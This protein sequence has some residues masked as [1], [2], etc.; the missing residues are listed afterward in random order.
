[1]FS[2]PKFSIKR[3]VCIFI[4]I[5]SLIIFGTSS[6]FQMPMESTPEMEFPILMVMTSYYG[7]SPE[8]IDESVTDKIESALS[9]VS[10][11][12]TTM[13]V[14]MENVGMTMLEFSYDADMD[15]KYQDVTSALAM[16]SLP[17]G[18]SDPTV[19][20]MNIS[21]MAN[22]SIM[23]LSIEASSGE[24]LKAYVE[25][26]IVP[27]LERIEGVS[28]VSIFGGSRQY[29]QILLDENKM[30]QYHLT[31]SSVAN[32]IASSE[33]EITM[34]SLD[35]GNVTVELT[36][37]QE[38]DNYRTLE[39]V[40]ITLVSGDV[41]HLSDVAQVNMADEE[42]TSYSRRDGK[43]TMSLSIM[44]DQ[45]ANTVSIC[46]QVAQVVDQLNHSNLGLTMEIT[47][48][49]GQDI[50]DNLSQVALA[51]VEGLAIAV[52]VLWL[53]LGEWRASLIIG[54]SMPFSVLATLILMSAFGMTINLISLGGLVIGIGM[55]VD[56][57]IVVIDSCFKSGTM[58]RSFEENIIKGAELVMGSITASTLTTVV[59]FLPI[60][61][62]DGLAGQLFHDICYTIVFSLTA[63]LISAITLVPL[64]FVKLKPKEKTDFLGNRLVHRLEA[65]YGRIMAKLFDKRALVVITAV[66]LMI[67]AVG[68]FAMVPKELIPDMTS[69]QIRL[70]VETKNGLNLESTNE[71][72][73]QLEELVSQQPDVESY[74]MQVG[75]S[76]GLATLMG[77]GAGTITVT[78]REDASMTESEFVQTIRD[79]SKSVPNCNVDVSSVSMMSML[80][81]G[82]VELNLRGR[83][84]NDLNEQAGIIRDRM[85]QMPEFD[86]VTTSLTDGAPR[87]KIQVDPILAASVNMTP[88]SVLASVRS[89]LSG[90]EAITI[91]DGG[92]EY[93]VVVELPTDRFQDVSDLYGMMVDTP[94][95]GKAALTD[96][97]EI[98]YAEAPTS[99][100]REGGDYLVT[101]TG[102]PKVGLNIAQLSTEVMNDIA[103]NVELPD[104]VEIDQ[105]SMMEQMYEEFAAIGKALL[106][107]VYLVFAVMAIQFESIR[108][109]GVVMIS[110]PFALVGSFLGLAITGS[111]VNMASLLG[112]VMLVGIVV[113]NAIVLID[114]TNILRREYGFEIRQAL[115]QA[116]ISRLRPIL[117]STLTTIVGLLPMA[118]GSG[119]EMMESMAVVVIG[120]LLMSTLLTLVL[121]PTFYLIFDPEDRR[122][123]R[124][125]RKAAKEKAQAAQ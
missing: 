44:K 105:G 3:P 119:V 33:F 6:V 92:T 16:V 37:S 98:V 118:L 72:M 5:A 91:Q 13:S 88:A 14:S 108:F 57:S 42:V 47:S 69:G 24:N 53:F 10:E 8:E 29:I 26:T 109:S 113:N 68:L 61:L 75:D 89:Q 1:M 90:V 110:V 117:M 27:E 11:V 62:M 43:D 97:A 58:E 2:L 38:I 111:S 9:T 49:S 23:S 80:S 101:V 81:G 34:G 124:E 85:A 78:L 12:E 103:A 67:T 122:R 93:S 63:S 4:C 87:A 82:T 66:A 65:W 100:T 20:E 59:V 102:T 54:L 35:R 114:Y 45:S 71:I 46:N 40:P 55:L 60:G 32:A 74:S 39:D 56:N 96:M 94:T 123:R 104:G 86:S 125:Q 36:G 7:A 120:G 116:G 83:N 17:D 19:M 52:V 107:A 28:D 112:V 15:K 76:S 79:L 25:D 95:G 77:S 106:I 84:L 31:M 99:I 48:N 115:R 30:T 64:L 18:C 22:S 73:T 41:I 121:I 70:S 21:N 50:L 51:L